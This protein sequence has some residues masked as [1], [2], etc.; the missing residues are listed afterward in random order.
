MKN[1]CPPVDVEDQVILKPRPPL[2]GSD[3]K[4][5]HNLLVWDEISLGIVFP[6][7]LPNSGEFEVPPFLE[8]ILVST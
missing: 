5:K 6:Q 1:D 2:L 4:Y 3:T 8:Y 7:Y